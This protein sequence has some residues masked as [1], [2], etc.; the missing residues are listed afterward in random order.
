MDLKLD[1]V[2]TR[3]LWGNGLINVFVLI[4]SHFSGKIINKR[5]VAQT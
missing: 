3:L 4:N 5:Y 1:K 2:M